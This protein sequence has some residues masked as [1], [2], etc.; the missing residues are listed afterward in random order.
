MLSLSFVFCAASQY[1]YFIYLFIC[2]GK[3]LRKIYYLDSLL[4]LFDVLTNISLIDFHQTFWK[5]TFHSL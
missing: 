4:L 1:V 3:L 2:G 5:T